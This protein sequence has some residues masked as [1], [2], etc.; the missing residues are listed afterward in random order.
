MNKDTEQILEKQTAEAKKLVASADKSRADLTPGEIL[1]G[2]VEDAKN[3]DFMALVN[4]ERDAWKRELEDLKP[5]VLNQDGSF[6]QDAKTEMRQYNVLEK[7]I[8][9]CKVSKDHYMIHAIERL[10]VAASKSGYA[11]S[12]VNG[13]I[14]LYTGEY[15]VEVGRERFH[16]FLSQYAVK[17]GV[18]EI[19]GKHF[20][21][22]DMLLDQF[23]GAHYLEIQ[24]P[25]P[26]TVVINLQNGAFEIAP[27]SQKLREFRKS[28]FLK[29]K[30]SYDYDPEATCPLF[31]EYI[32]RCLPSEDVRRV[33]YEV[34]GYIFSRSKTLSLESLPVFFGSGANGK[35]LALKIISELAG[36]QNVSNY[37]LASLT[38]ANGYSR[39]QIGDK[40]VNICT[41]I[42]GNVESDYFKILA[43]NEPIDAR[44]PFGIPFI[45]TEY[46]K[47]IVAANVLPK[48]VEHSEGYHRRWLI[49]P[50]DA[51]IPK[52][53][54]D[55][56]LF[57]K[58]INNGELSGIFNHIL[59]GLKRLIAHRK[60]SPCSEIDNA[61]K[62]FK[63]ESNSTLMFL[64]ESGYEV[65]S[66]VYESI[67]DLYPKFVNYCRDAG[68][69]AFSRI[70]FRRELEKSGILVK[71]QSVGL[72]A[73]V[74]SNLNLDDEQSIF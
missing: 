55:P 28:D 16:W 5:I 30:L 15:W 69:K 31:Q 26:D 10:G 8:A 49:L 39:A 34:A 21:F 1:N 18:P 4:P 45:L 7:K 43:S 73:Y 62:S 51:K 23:M 14:Y 35:S 37:S 46:G 71:R 59:D 56:D 66:K 64:D 27:K 11:F 33:F 12:K 63:K 40:L 22:K 52:E 36:K 25:D 65:S 50:W 54:R 70:N 53:E 13:T 67:A 24:K 6:N 29:Y 3:I 2:I 68:T 38:D 57:N 47:I 32:T 41:E 74:E 44:S 48:S 20:R 58:I 19:F 61:A 42:S 9:G 72:V 17:V 60:F